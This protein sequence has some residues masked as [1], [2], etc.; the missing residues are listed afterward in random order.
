MSLL[1]EIIPIRFSE[2]GNWPGVAKVCA[3]AGLL[4]SIIL[5]GYCLDWT[6][7]WAALVQAQ[8]RE[9]ELKN[10]YLLRKRSVMN[11]DVL[12]LQLADVEQT[13]HTLLAQMSGKSELDALLVD[14]NR[15]GLGRGLQFELFKP[16]AREI[17]QDFYAELP[18]TFRATGSYHDIGAFA[19]DLALLPRIVTLHDIEIIPAQNHQLVLH[20]VAKTYRYL[21]EASAELNEAKP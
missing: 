8:T 11:L 1:V 7:Q 19:S 13:L 3:L 2:P 5:A 15:A 16:A 21:D 18:V 6:T 20:A 14:I 12:R 10:T 4:G 9:A 17:I